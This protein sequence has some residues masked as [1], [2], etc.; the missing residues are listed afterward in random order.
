MLLLKS[1]VVRFHSQ[2]IS[3]IGKKGSLLTAVENHVSKPRVGSPNS[4]NTG[5]LVQLKKLRDLISERSS[6]I[7]FEEDAETLET[8]MNDLNGLLDSDTLNPQNIVFSVPKK[9]NTKTGSYARG[10]EMDKVFGHYRSTFYSSKHKGEDGQKLGWVSDK[11]NTATP[12]IYQALFGGK[13]VA[14][15]LV[16]VLEK[17]I[18][19]ID[20]QRFVAEITTSK[21]AVTLQIIP[22]FRKRL[23]S[24]IGRSRTEEGVSTSKVMRLMSGK[25]FKV[26]PTGKAQKMLSRYMKID[27]LGGTIVEFTIKLSPAKTRKLIKDYMGSNMSVK[28]SPIIKSWKEVLL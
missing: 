15:G 10:V 12:P 6:G 4:P 28:V 24:A 23:G 18:N 21:P 25:S 20:D 2:R 17:A 7:Y 22:D 27:E 26:P 11:L 1:L 14:I 8:I 16:D 19:D 5:A 13:L 9:F 3:L